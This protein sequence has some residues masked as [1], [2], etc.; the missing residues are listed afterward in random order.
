VVRAVTGSIAVAAA[1]LLSGCTA[2]LPDVTFYG[3]RTTVAADPS[4]WCAADAAG[5]KVDCRVAKGDGDAPRL[6]VAKGH[7][8]SVNLPATLGA[9]PWVV[10]FQYRDAAGATQDARGPLFAAGARQD[11][12]LR[13]PSATDQLVRVEVQSG[14]TPIATASGS[15]VDYAAMRTWVLVIDPA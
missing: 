12:I 1:L 6:T 13:P 15:G 9:A 4:L 14:L 11:Y 3:G 2:P 7:A 8:V 10:L 5:S